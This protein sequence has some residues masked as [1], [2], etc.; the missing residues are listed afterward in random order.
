MTDLSDL[1][2]ALKREI[3]EPGQFAIVYPGVTDTTLVGYLMDAFSQAQLEGYFPT[4]VLD[5]DNETVTPD[6]S[7]GGQAFVVM[8]AGER[9]LVQKI[10]NMTTASRYQA[11]PVK[12]ETEHSASVLTEILKQLRARRD[13]ITQMATGVG[14]PSSGVYTID[15]Y[16]DRVAVGWGYTY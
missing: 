14:G 5:V 6:L 16:C 9:I 4:S 2:P 11:G 10:M 15:Q 7:P 12:Y 1:V 3:A 13:R 8:I